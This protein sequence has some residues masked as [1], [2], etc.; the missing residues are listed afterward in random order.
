[1]S[2]CT[3]DYHQCISI[4]PI[5]KGLSVDQMRE[6]SAIT[7]SRLYRKGEMI[8]HAGDSRRDLLVIHTGKVKVYR[9]SEE[10][11]EQVIRLV[12]PGEFLGELSLFSSKKQT[13]YAEALEEVQMCVIAWNRLGTLMEKSSSIAFKI[14]EQ[15]SDRLEQTERL[16]EESNL[17]SVTQRIVRY[18]LQEAKSASSVTLSLSKGDLASLLGMSQETLSRCISMLEQKRLIELHGQRGIAIL[19]P[20]ALAALL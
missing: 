12:G 16:L 2:A 3:T 11:K 13:D 19:N 7:S 14:M 20:K 6:L 4:V 10:G 15:L 1:M 18:L 17:K 5:F 9:I 8:Y